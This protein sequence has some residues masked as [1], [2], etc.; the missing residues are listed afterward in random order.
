MLVSLILL[1]ATAQSAPATCEALSK[2]YDA[3][4]R[5]YSAQHVGRDRQSDDTALFAEASQI[6][7][8]MQAHKCPVP[9][10][11]VGNYYSMA[12]YQCLRDSS[13]PRKVRYLNSD[14][15]PAIAE[16]WSPAG[17]P[18]FGSALVTAFP[19]ESCDQDKWK[20]D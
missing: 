8:L 18:D 12:A 17:I 14:G 1:A 11:P 5:R 15:S 10:E 7:A 16:S 6:V 3:L 19:P 9:T 4:S 13:D 20:R 2:R